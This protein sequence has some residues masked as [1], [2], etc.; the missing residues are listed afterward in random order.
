MCYSSILF[1]GLAQPWRMCPRYVVGFFL[2][3]NSLIN[4]LSTQ[5]DFVRYFTICN[6]KLVVVDPSL[7]DTALNALSRIPSLSFVPT[8]ALGATNG[9]LFSVR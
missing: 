1:S 7:C 3:L 9:S 5:D 4:P 8:I 6:P 2:I